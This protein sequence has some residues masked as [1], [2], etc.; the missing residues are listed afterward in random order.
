VKHYKQYESKLAQVVDMYKDSESPTKRRKHNKNRGCCLAAII[1]PTY[2]VH[3]DGN[4]DCNMQDN[5]GKK[6]QRTGDSCETTTQ[7]KDSLKK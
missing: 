6:R 5:R 7:T 1:S 3:P 4:R 2:P